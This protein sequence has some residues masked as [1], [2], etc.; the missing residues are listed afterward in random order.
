MK[1]NRVPSPNWNP[2]PDGMA[3][4][5]IVLHATASDDVDQDVAWCRD[6]K[7]EVSYHVIIDRFGAIWDLV[8]VAHRAWHAG[9]SKFYGRD[10]GE[11]SVNGFSIG[12]SFA[13]KND[14]IEDYT[15]EQYSVGAALVAGYIR[16]YPAITLDRIT[17]H[18][19]I[20]LPPGRK[21]DP[22]PP[23][24]IDRFKYLVGEELGQ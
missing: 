16:E 6:R 11:G 14:N 8:D 24:D 7:S 4:D 5:C 12:V 22:T 18:K 13:N 17:M 20:A 2:R 3:I 15:D 21:T 9:V 19:V 10:D 1:I 23:F